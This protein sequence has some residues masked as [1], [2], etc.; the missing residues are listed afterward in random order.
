[1]AVTMTTIDNMAIE[2]IFVDFL[3]SC[4]G[5]DLF[6]ALDLLVVSVYQE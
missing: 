4:A 1:M 2:I 5:S 3:G 6:S